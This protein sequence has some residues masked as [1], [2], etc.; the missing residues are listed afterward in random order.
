V[1]PETRSELA[2]PMIHKGRVIGV[3]DLESPQLNYFTDDH[4]QT[5]SIL[6]ANFAVSLENARLYEQVARDEARLERD[7][8]AAKRIQGALLRSVPTED[9]GLDMA[10]RYLSAREVGGDL[11][12]FLRYGPQQLGIALGDVSGKGTAAALYGAVA[13]GIMRSL[14]PQKLQPAELL[15]QMN[16]IIGERRIEGRFM[17]ACFATFQKGRSKLRVA[18]AGQSQPL[19]YKEG[20]CGKVELTGFPLGIFEEVTYDEWSVTLSAGDILVFHSDGIA[21]T[22]NSE[23]QFFG[24]ERLRKIIE[25]QHELASAELADQ[26]FREVEWFAQGAPLADDRTLVVLKVR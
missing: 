11:Y 24:T 21:E 4:V 20:R 16:Q 19:L 12:E 6:A 2:I 8:Q 7:L 10:A 17:T 1:N 26:V 23:G 25:D 18:N 22:A 5:L 3:L 9:F 14:A 13:I 15:R